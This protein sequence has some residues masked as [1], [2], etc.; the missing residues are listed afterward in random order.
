MRDILKSHYK[1]VG[2]FTVVGVLNTVIDFS[3]F[4]LLHDVFDIYFIIAHVCGFT[5]ALCNSFY[6]NA[7]WTFNSLDKKRWHRQAVCFAIVSVVGMGLSTLTIYIANAFVWVYFA[8]AL[9][10]IVSFLWNYAASFFIVFKKSGNM[11]SG[12]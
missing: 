10:T 12:P 7:T 11:G 2:K 6:F 8:K 9:A 1:S 5:L 4:Y 3:V